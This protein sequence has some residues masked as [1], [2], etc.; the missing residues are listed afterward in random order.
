[1]PY[2]LALTYRIGIII[3][4]CGFTKIDSKAQP[5]EMR[6]DDNWESY[7]HRRIYVTVSM[8]PFRTLLKCAGLYGRSI[9]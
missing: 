3:G 9:I 7:H 2:T 8:P 4:S 6:R 1:M 5:M